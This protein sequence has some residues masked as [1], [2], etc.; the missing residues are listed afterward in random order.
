MMPGV[1]P[2]PVHFTLT[3]LRYVVAVDTHRHFGAAAAA[4]HV[5]QSTLSMQ[6]RKLERA[7][8]VSLFDRSR[9]PVVA[10]DLGR[11]IIEQ[12]RVALREA[13]R[14][15]ELRDDSLGVVAGELRLGVLPTLAPYLLPT[16][17]T[18][19]RRRHPSL[20]LV[21]EELVTDD[22]IRALRLDRLDAGLVAT[23]VN[24]GDLVHQPLF[25][26]PFVGYVSPR[27]RLAKRKVLTTADLSL[28]DLWLLSEGHCFR[29]EVLKLCGERESAASR[30]LS[31]CT[32][33]ARFESG[34]LETLKR[35]VEQ[36]DG[37]TLLP[38]LAAA[39]LRGERQRRLIRPFASPVPEREVRLVQRRAYLK[40]HLIAAVVAVILESLPPALTPTAA[41]RPRG[42]RRPA[43]PRM[44]GRTD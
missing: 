25:R 32:H 22:I 33:G 24:V 9:M 4:C 10:T 11:V 38:A 5:S 3:Q 31:A 28:D 23:P 44:R 14:I 20:E 30:P 42:R 26:E 13:D 43:S 21:I 15:G 19:L 35:L 34:N 18:T 39:D 17:L 37:M 6:L 29:S 40:R 1:P 36:G 16:C 12:A 8:A 2:L 7:L 41:L 27:H